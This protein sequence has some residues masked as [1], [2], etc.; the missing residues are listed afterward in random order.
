MPRIRDEATTSSSTPRV[1][2]SPRILGH[3]NPAQPVVQ[4]PFGLSQYPEQTSG[5]SSAPIPTTPRVHWTPKCSKTTRITGSQDHRITGSQDHRITRS[6][7]KLDS[8][9]I[10]TPRSSGALIHS[11]SQLRLQHLF[12]HPA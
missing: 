10:G 7:R 12:Q 4:V 1:T 6:Q 3:R 2:G 9:E 8:Q 5:T 11:R